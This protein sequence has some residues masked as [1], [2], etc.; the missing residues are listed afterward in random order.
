VGRLKAKKGKEGLF[1]L[2]IAQFFLVV[3]LYFA[4]IFQDAP[5]S[6][7]IAGT[8]LLLGAILYFSFKGIKTLWLKKKSGQK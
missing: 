7:S 2:L 3:L 4:V 6:L 5:R 1:N 8:L